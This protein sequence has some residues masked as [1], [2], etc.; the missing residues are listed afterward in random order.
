MAFIAAW[1]DKCMSRPSVSSEDRCSWH[2]AQIGAG[3]GCCVDGGWPAHAEK[4]ERCED[5]A[6]RKNK[7]PEGIIQVLQYIACL[8]VVLMCLR[9]EE[10]ILQHYNSTIFAI[11][12]ISS[13]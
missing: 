12:E 13:R 4:E 8:L 3:R 1:S 11:N 9:T 5:D 10:G 6:S 7:F 2:T